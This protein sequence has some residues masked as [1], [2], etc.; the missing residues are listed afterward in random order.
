MD[1]HRPPKS[2]NVHAN[3]TGYGVIAEALY[4][5]LSARLKK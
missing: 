5:V 2:P 1:V 4:A 3:K